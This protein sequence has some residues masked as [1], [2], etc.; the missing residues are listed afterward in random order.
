MEIDYIVMSC[1][2]KCS[3]DIGESLDEE[4]V[5]TEYYDE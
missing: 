5:T 1:K 2:M 4:V 3:N